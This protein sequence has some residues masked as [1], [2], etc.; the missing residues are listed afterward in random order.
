MPWWK[1]W[2][3]KKGKFLDP[4]C[5]FAGRM[6]LSFVSLFALDVLASNTTRIV[7]KLI[8][9]PRIEIKSQVPSLKWQK[10]LGMFFVDLV[11]PFVSKH[12]HLSGSDNGWK[13]FW[14]YGECLQSSIMLVLLCL[15]VRFPVWSFA[16]PFRNKKMEEKKQTACPGRPR[17]YI[18][19]PKRAWRTSAFSQRN[20]RPFQKPLSWYP[21]RSALN[22]DH[23]QRGLAEGYGRRW[24]GGVKGVD[25]MWWRLS[26]LWN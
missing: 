10:S 1:C 16:S 12:S 3:F 8:G 23:F 17:S 24:E 25:I 15:P 9:N 22:Q 6:L 7:S 18:P 20:W 19:I 5:S 21:W 2:V 4:K 13:W 26:S 11:R 14:K